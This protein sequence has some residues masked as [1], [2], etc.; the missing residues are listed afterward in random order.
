MSETPGRAPDPG[1]GLR[2]IGSATLWMEALVL[3]FALVGINGMGG[4]AAGASLALVGALA[5]LCIAVAFL[6]KFAAG[7][8]I[9][10]ALQAFVIASGAVSWPL[11]ALG[12]VFAGLWLLYLR[13]L[14]LLASGVLH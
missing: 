10:L 9:G 11:Y 13:Y 8:A 5:V 3:G 12:A 2:R 4:S 7:P 6:Q 14:H 1:R